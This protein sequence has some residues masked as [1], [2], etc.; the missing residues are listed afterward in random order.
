MKNFRMLRQVVHIITTALSRGKQTY[1]KKIDFKLRN[2]SLDLQ[3]QLGVEGQ[4]FRDRVS[5]SSM[6]TDKVTKELDL[7]SEFLQLVTQDDFITFSN[8]KSFTSYMFKL[9]S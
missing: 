6:E 7:K 2:S 8:R 5:S 9:L 1:T 4:Y 3:H